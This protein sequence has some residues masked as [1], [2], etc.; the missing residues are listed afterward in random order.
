M[1]STHFSPCC[2]IPLCGTMKFHP[3]H[4]IYRYD[5]SMQQ[6]LHMH[7]QSS[8]GVEALVCLL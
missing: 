5:P 2:S 4:Q 3:H 6:Q 7:E 1:L 8:L